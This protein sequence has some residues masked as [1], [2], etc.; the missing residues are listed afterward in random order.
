MH[1]ARRSDDDCAF[2]P[3][4]A[5]STFETTV[6]QGYLEGSNVSAIEE[7]VRLITITRLYQGNVKSLESADDGMKHLL[8]VAMGS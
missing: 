6:R 5:N 2:F 7:L 8:D 4:I 1:K 3:S